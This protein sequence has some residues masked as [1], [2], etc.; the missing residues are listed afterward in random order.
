MLTLSLLLTTAAID[1]GTLLARPIAV[2][3][4]SL[5]VLGQERRAIYQGHAK[6][7]RDTTTLTCQTL[8][9]HYNAKRE[10]ERIDALG[11]IEAKDGERWAKGEE[12][13]YDNT[14]GILVVTGN[15]QARHGPRAVQGEEV[16][17]TTGSEKLEVKKAR[18]IVEGE[19]NLKRVEIDA[20]QLVM[21]SPKHLA[22]WSGHVKARR[23]ATT[24]RAPLLVA[25]Y[26][27]GGA[28]TR[29]EAK[30]GVEVTDRDKWAKGQRADF[31][32]QT[33]VLIVTGK[34]EAKQ[35]NNRMKGSKVTFVSGSDKLEV[36]N[37]TTLIEATPKASKP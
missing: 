15:P 20:D 33:G 5:E 28:V 12:A 7:V 37:A 16:R 26:D 25:H 29:V 32:N 13:T 4:D 34:P 8:T 1:G 24:L 6:V 30:G 35:G 19:R 10:V 3:A 23:D 27:E 22:T 18:T 14:T 17:F 2:T 11:A 36:D 21:E 31:D 9:V